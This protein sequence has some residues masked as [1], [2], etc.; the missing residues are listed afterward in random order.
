MVA[1]S[2]RIREFQ[3]LADKYNGKTTTINQ[4]KLCHL[5][6]EIP[7][8]GVTGMSASKMREMAKNDDYRNFR[9]GVVGLNDSDTRK[10]YDAV[11]KGMDIRESYV[12]KFTDFINNDIREEYHQEKYLMWVIW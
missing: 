5:A 8:E 3:A 1:G 11:R 7:I 6:K 9:R 12:D 2:D 4:S 10:L